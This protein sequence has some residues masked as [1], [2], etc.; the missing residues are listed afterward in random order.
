MPDQL[1][2]SHI[3][4]AAHL[5]SKLIYSVQEDEDRQIERRRCFRLSSYQNVSIVEI[6]QHVRWEVPATLNEITN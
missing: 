3:T 1:L 5:Q 2:N 4:D 6:Y